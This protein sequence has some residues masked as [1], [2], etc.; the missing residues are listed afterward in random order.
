MINKDKIKLNQQKY[1]I[2]GKW[3]SSHSRISILKVLSDKMVEINC[4]GEIFSINIIHIYNTP[5][6]AKNGFKL[7]EKVIKANKK[8]KKEEKRQRQKAKAAQ[9]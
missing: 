3:S 7:Y 2:P 4:R 5:E 9:N 6:A 1:Y 8:L